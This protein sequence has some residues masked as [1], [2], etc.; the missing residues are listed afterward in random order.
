MFKHSIY[1]RGVNSMGKPNNI[2]FLQF[3]E[4]KQAS[5]DDDQKGSLLE[6][7]EKSFEKCVKK[8][9]THLEKSELN[10]KITFK[11]EGAQQIVIRE[12]IST[13]CPTAKGKPYIA[14]NDARGKIYKVH[15]DQTL[16]ELDTT[17]QN[18]KTV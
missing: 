18:S 9:Y 1:L 16:L 14:F 3:L 12:N 17:I 5:N 6:I 7:L 11:P 15:P 13:N 2:T 10:L 8:S 4:E